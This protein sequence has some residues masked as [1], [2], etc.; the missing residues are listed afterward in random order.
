[1]LKKRGQNKPCQIAYL[2]IIR[3]KIS[4]LQMNPFVAEP[5][6]PHLLPLPNCKTITEPI[7]RDKYL[8]RRITFK[9]TTTNVNTKITPVIALTTMAT[10]SIIIISMQTTDN[11]ITVQ[12][13]RTKISIHYPHTTN[14]SINKTIINL[15]SIKI[16]VVTMAIVEHMVKWVGTIKRIRLMAAGTTIISRDNSVIKS[17]ELMDSWIK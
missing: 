10:N 13:T 3:A 12:I 4:S 7:I 5:Q 2:L 6:V 8:K 9:G 14:S 16:T 17:R 15:I 11:H 1:M